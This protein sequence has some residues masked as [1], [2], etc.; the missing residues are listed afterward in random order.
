MDATTTTPLVSPEWL[1]E[2]LDDPHVQVV[3]VD[4]SPFAHQEGHIPGSVLWNIYADLKDGQYRLRD[5]AELEAL[6]QRSGITADT[7][8]V[9]YGYGPALGLWLLTWLGHPAVALLDLG[10]DAWRDQGR[11]WTDQATE[12]A[13]SAYRLGSPDAD[14]R[15]TYAQVQAAVASPGTTIVDVRTTDEYDGGRFWPS[16]GMEEGGRAG[17][18]PGAV[19]IG[20]DDLLGPDGGFRPT[21]ELAARLDGTRL[22]HPVITYCTIGARAATAW[23]VLTHLLGH[24]RVR[25]YDGSW[26]EWGRSPGAPV[27]C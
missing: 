17:H 9:F 19:R 21:S 10:R 24:D 7:T 5:R 12:R 6:V 1:A 26:A 15:A 27:E 2:H 25:V 4:V 22:D 3:E 8:V 14:V 13:P 16:G 23:F 11:P 18:V 20:V